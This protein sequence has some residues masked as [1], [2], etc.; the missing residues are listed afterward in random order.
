MDKTDI[1]K[2]GTIAEKIKAHNQ[3]VELVE[4]GYKQ[5][6]QAK[7]ILDNEF[8][9]DSYFYVMPHSHQ[10]C[11]N[12]EEAPK[13]VTEG[14]KRQAWKEL[15]DSLEINRIMSIERGDETAEK[16]NKGELPPL[17][18][19][20]V[21]EVFEML[22]QNINSFAR[23]S[24]KEIFEWI[25]PHEL[26]HGDSHYKTNQKNARIELGKKIIHGGMV[27]LKYSRTGY[28]VSYRN[29]KYL[30][31]LDRV[32]HMLEGKNML[33]NSHRSPIVDAINLTDASGKA[34]TD[35]FKCKCYQNGNIHIEF[36]R[37]DLVGKFNAM[38]GGMNLKPSNP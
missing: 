19:E 1:V 18:I 22:N 35:Y 12:P 24:V 23:E 30:T 31:A 3:A 34:E 14:I 8:G 6:A 21:Y 25:R 9:K 13:I 20:A 5:L 33:E 17:T 15:Y 36:K 16:L 27:E 28:Q 2:R 32:F 37:L 38:A 7:E 11:T 10:S 26:W 29:E 4:A